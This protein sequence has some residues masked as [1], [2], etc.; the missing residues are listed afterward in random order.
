[1]PGILQCLNQ[2]SDAPVHTIDQAGVDLTVSDEGRKQ[3]HI[4]LMC[5]RERMHT[6]ATIR[7]YRVRGVVRHEQ[8]ERVFVRGRGIDEI[9]PLVSQHIGHVVGVGKRR[10]RRP[11]FLWM[12]LTTETLVPIRI[13]F[14][15]DCW[16]ALVGFPPWANST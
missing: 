2:L 7:Q 3:V 15:V 4:G 9:D 11:V 12:K 8:E 6:P 5:L 14:G 1:M 10:V 16:A 13:V